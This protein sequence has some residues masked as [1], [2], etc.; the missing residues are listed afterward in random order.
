MNVYLYVLDTLADWEIGY[1]TAEVHSRRFFA[2]RDI[3]CRLIKVGNNRSPV[4]TMGG[5]KITPDITIDAMN[6]GKD[7]ILV[8]PGGDTWMNAE[9]DRILELAKRR[10]EADLPVA[11]ICG[12][13]IGL[14]RTG[15]LNVKKHT[16]N[17]MNYLKYVAKQ[18]IGERNYVNR[19]AV[20]DRNL[21]T[22][23]GQSAVEFTYEVLK[24]LKLFK[25]DTLEA[26]RGLY[27]TNE[28]RY[29]FDM[30]KSLEPQNGR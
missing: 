3:E 9:N 2:N 30:M 25:S 6:G 23:S 19:P 21:I 8:L 11:A 5:M 18:Y 14:A 7:D 26:W 24:V 27:L 22:A 12:G 20:N 1:L 16:S 15:S 29:F 17:D 28:A 4:T 13:T 10:I